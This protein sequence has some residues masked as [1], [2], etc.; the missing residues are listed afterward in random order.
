MGDLWGQHD[1]KL[2]GASALWDSDLVDS[3]FSKDYF[4]TIT[5]L[6]YIYRGAKTFSQVYRGAK[7]EAQI[8][9]G[10]GNLFP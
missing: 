5:V 10:A 7:T 3:I 9:R 8:Y 6:S 1:N 2:S 4:V